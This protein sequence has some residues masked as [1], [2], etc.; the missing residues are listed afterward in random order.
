MK[1]TLPASFHVWRDDDSTKNLIPMRPLT[2]AA[3]CGSLRKASLNQRALTA[4]A[5]HLPSHVQ[6]HRLEIAELPLYS[7][8]ITPVPEVVAALKAGVKDADGVVIVTPE[9]NYGIPGGLKNA[10]DWASRP[11]YKS[12]FARK[13]VTMLGASPGQAGTAR[14]QAQLKQVLLG[15]LSEI[16]PCPE[17][18]I[19]AADKKFSETGEVLDPALEAALERHARD[20][21]AWLEPRSGG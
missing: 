18:L 2:L 6:L 3:I 20:F 11:G 13:P 7:D 12:V 19:G 9:Y 4:W 10:L 8:D 15:M 5:R 1:V 17:L 14:A 16:Y 21:V